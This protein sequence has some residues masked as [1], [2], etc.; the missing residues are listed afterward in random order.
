M[1]SVDNAAVRIYVYNIHM[2]REC[3][4]DIFK[5]LIVMKTFLMK[6]YRNLEALIVTFKVT[7]FLF[8]HRKF[9]M[10]WTSFQRLPVLYSHF[11]FVPKVTS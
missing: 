5:P 3:M 1:C 4:H 7:F 8:C 9:H 11:F 2:Y 6:R 10:N